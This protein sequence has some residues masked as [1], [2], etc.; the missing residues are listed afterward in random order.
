MDSL[1]IGTWFSYDKPKWE[2]ELECCD[3]NVKKQT[4]LTRKELINVL[5]VIYENNIIN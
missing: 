4:G 3:D 1:N 2:T 5:T